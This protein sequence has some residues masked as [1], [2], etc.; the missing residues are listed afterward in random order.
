M[1]VG[2]FWPLRKPP[3]GGIP[4][5]A[6]KKF[7]SWV[8]PIIIIRMRLLNFGQFPFSSTEMGV[9]VLYSKLIIGNRNSL[10]KYFEYY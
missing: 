1:G 3:W 9:A 8:P 7:N 10:I 5:H 4:L 2:G 6:K